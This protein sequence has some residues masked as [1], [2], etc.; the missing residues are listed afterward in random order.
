ME[1]SKLRRGG[2]ASKDPGGRTELKTNAHCSLMCP[3]PRLGFPSAVQRKQAEWVKGTSFQKVKLI[4]PA[5]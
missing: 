1:I 5:S 3:H 4:A 2:V